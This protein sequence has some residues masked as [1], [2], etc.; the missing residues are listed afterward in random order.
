MTVGKEQLDRTLDGLL[1]AIFH[2]EI[3]GWY[4][5][6]KAALSDH[7]RMWGIHGILH[8]IIH[9]IFHVVIHGCTFQ[10]ER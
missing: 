7:C 9:A 6:W 8:G 2:F 1:A 4:G 3:V 5:G 10:G